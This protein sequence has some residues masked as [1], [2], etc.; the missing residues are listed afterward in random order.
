MSTNGKRWMGVV[1][2]W[3]LGG[4]R[5]GEVPPGMGEPERER[6]EKKRDY[7]SSSPNEWLLRPE[8]FLFFLFY[9]Y[10]SGDFSHIFFNFRLLNVFTFCGGRLEML[11]GEN[12]DMRFFKLLRNRQGRC[13]DIRVFGV[14]MNMML[15]NLMICRGIFLFPFPSPPPMYSVIVLISFLS[16]FLAGF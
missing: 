6:D 14:L 2:E 16:F 11:N 13:M 12:V 5:G 8:V 15:K 9:L 1:E 10:L 7:D 4:R 3:E